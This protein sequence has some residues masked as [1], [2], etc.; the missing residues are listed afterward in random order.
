MVFFI[1]PSNEGVLFVK[2]EYFVNFTSWSLKLLFSYKYKI[3][4]RTIS[5]TVV[6]LLR[7]VSA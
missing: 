5:D 6:T 2:L 1:Y 4:A 7:Q 3:N